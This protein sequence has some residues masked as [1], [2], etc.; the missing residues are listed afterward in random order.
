MNLN[1]KKSIRPVRG[2]TGVPSFLLAMLSALHAGSAMATEEAAGEELY[3]SNLPVVATVS[4]LPQPLSEAPGAVTVIDR[5][6]IRAS[7]ARNFADLLRLVPGFQVTPPNQEGAIVAYH[8]LSNEEYTPRV[9]VLIDGRS[10]Y[11]SLFLSGVNWNLLPVALEDIERIEVSRGS[12]SVSYGSSAFLGVINIITLDAS[13]ARGWMM[14]VKHG[15]QSVRDET[16]RWGGRIGAADV[17]FTYQ[18]Q[19]DGGFRRMF[20]GS[21]G[22]FDPHDS[23]HAKLLDLRADIPLTARDELRISISQ[24]SDISQFGRPGSLSDPFRDLSQS[25]TSFSS[26]WRRT[27]SEAEELRLR[28]SHVEDWASGHYVERVSYTDVNSNDVAYFSMNNTGGKSISNQIE[29]QHIFSP[30]R[31]MRMVWGG[32]AQDVGVS[33]L[34]QFFTTDEKHRSNF[35]LFGNLE[36][37][38]ASQWLFNFGSSIEHDSLSGDIIDPRLGASYHITP[39]HTLRLVASRAH[40]APSLYESLGDLR[41]MPIGASTPVDRVYLAAPGLKPEQVDTLEV[42]YLGEFKRLGASLDLRVF[43]E[44]IPNRITFVPYALSAANADSRD[45]LGDRLRS[46]D[47]STYLFGRADAALN[48]ER[49]SIQGY[50]YQWNWQVFDA[51]RLMY[52][53]AYIRTF[54]NLTDVSVIADRYGETVDKI[55]RQTRQSAPRHSTSA[56]LMQRLPYNLE[57]SLMY[58]KSGYMRWLRNSF[59]SPYE[60][61]DWRL[62]RQFHLGNARAE[63]AYTAQIVNHPEDGRRNTRIATET[64]WLSLRLEF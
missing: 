29:L 21:L 55:L 7:G 34:Y 32:S 9:Q 47:A 19:G 40:R 62:A 20:D 50:E 56:M 15:N 4:R 6:I 1:Q 22:W 17:R 23:R 51:T 26:E 36:W 33:S 30:W 12:N 60:R 27:L 63:V 10:Q 48:L 44:S 38:P 8:G 41:K 5:E 25:S 11:S 18:Q 59:T 57:A 2:A 16:L 46:D 61:V 39:E 52:S 14:S 35:R 53:Y 24:A 49:V 3:F 64:H 54:A 43:H 37:R 28:F 45:N 13:Q 58:S 31:Q 42:G